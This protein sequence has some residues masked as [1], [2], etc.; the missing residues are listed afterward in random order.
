MQRRFD[1]SEDLLDGFGS[2]LD[3]GHGAIAG[4]H[5]LEAQGCRAMPLLK[6]T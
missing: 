6:V 5:E 2:F 3:D 4:G 1:S